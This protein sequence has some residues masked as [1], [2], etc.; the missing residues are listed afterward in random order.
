MCGVCV[1]GV[2]CVCGV[3]GV[4]VVCVLCGV[5]GM[6]VWGGWCVCGVCGVCGVCLYHIIIYHHP[7]GE[8]G[9]FAVS[10]SLVNNTF[11]DVS[12]E[13]MADLILDQQMRC[14]VCRCGAC[15][16][17][18]CGCVWVHVCACVCAHRKFKHITYN[19]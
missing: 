3:C 1:C 18:V 13:C 9:G 12:R 2:W 15:R 16:C 19:I 17:G 14:G 10:D 7:V 11:W 5:C 8:D 6:C 4:C